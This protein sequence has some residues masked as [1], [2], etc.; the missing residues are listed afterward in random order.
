MSKAEQ[1]DTKLLSLLNIVD[2]TAGYINMTQDLK[3]L[4][5]AVADQMGKNKASPITIGRRG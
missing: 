3:D 5:P 2:L 1:S 4:V